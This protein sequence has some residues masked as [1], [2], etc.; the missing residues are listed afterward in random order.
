MSSP[1][2]QTLIGSSIN[3]SEPSDRCSQ[4]IPVSLPLLERPLST[5]IY[6]PHDEWLENDSLQEFDTTD[7]PSWLWALGVWK[8]RLFASLLSSA[9]VIGLAII[10]ATFSE[11][12]LSDFW[13]CMQG[14]TVSVDSGQH[15]QTV[16]LAEEVSSARVWTDPSKK[17]GAFS[18]VP[19]FNIMGRNF[20][21]ATLSYP[22]LRLQQGDNLLNVTM[23]SV[24]DSISAREITSE[25]MY[26]NGAPI[27]EVLVGISEPPF[28]QAWKYTIDDRP[29]WCN[30][31]AKSP[32]NAIR[33]PNQPGR[34][35]IPEMSGYMIFILEYLGLGSLIPLRYF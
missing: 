24:I 14:L 1:S 28:F 16:A 29:A 11:R 27:S 12:P 3:D 26:E 5:R 10:A 17:G 25:L 8:Y 30:R 20:S 19:G 7:K 21:A 22:S 6:R 34:A 35:S 13:Y 4:Q 2:E 9:G 23:L 33:L 31:I 15:K 32:A 18:D